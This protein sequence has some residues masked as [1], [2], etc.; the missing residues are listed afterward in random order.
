MP[1]FSGFVSKSLIKYA[2]KDHL[3]HMF[4]YTLI[5]IGTVT[6]FLKFSTILFGPKLDMIIIFRDSK[7]I[8]AMTILASLSI[9]MGIFYMPIIES[10]FGFKASQVQLLDLRAW[11]DYIIYVVIGFAFYRYI[12]KNDG[13]VLQRIRTFSM[14]FEDANYA[15]ILFMSVFITIMFFII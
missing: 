3:F 7:R 2:F 11:L 14:S 8:I 10:I 1:L 4:I 9:T 12:I 15:L 5:N 6:S 13:K